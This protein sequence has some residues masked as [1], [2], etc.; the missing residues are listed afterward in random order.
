MLNGEHVRGALELRL[1]FGPMQPVLS[2][3]L[4]LA[5]YERPADLVVVSGCAGAHVV[6]L[7]LLMIKLV[8]ILE[9]EKH[10]RWITAQTFCAPGAFA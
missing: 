8:F 7:L 3:I 6:S 4:N 9:T 10:S 1:P 2:F 5:S